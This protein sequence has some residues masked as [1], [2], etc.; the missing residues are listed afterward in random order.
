MCYV[1]TG[2]QIAGLE[3]R[4]GARPAVQLALARKQ[5][6]EAE[7]REIETFLE[8]YRKFAKKNELGDTRDVPAQLKTR[9]LAETFGAADMSLVEPQAPVKRDIRSRGMSQVDFEQIAREITP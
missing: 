1:T 4:C 5:Q 2:L 8:L 6:L 9:D 7:L 3:C